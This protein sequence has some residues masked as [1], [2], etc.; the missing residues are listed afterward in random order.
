M[1][2][3]AAAESSRAAASRAASS[4]LIFWMDWF[5][6]ST[7]IYSAALI[8]QRSGDYERKRMPAKLTTLASSIFHCW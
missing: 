2:A 1:I 3:A 7:R 5:R 4:S 8:A 6:E